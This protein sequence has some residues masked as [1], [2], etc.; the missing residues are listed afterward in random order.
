[1][2]IEHIILRQADQATT[3]A[4]TGLMDSSMSF[5]IIFNIFIAIYILYY[6]I[7]GSGK[8]YENDYPKE[9]QEAHNKFLRKFCWI[10]G[11]GLLIFSILEYANGFN[12]IWAIFSI[13]YVLG[14]IVVYAVTFRV[15]F[16]EYIQKTKP[17]KQKKTKK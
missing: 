1:M 11:I 13:A 8:I 4:A 12:S 5:M 6:A 10:T 17:V 7:K 16:K 9:M 2:G 14:C 3:E 15:R